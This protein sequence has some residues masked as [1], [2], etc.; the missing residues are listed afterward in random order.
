MAAYSRHHRHRLC[1]SAVGTST[2]QPAPPPARRGP[3]RHLLFPLA[4]GPI[5]PQARRYKQRRR[6]ASAKTPSLSTPLV[7]VEANPEIFLFFF[8]QKQVHVSSLSSRWKRSGS[9]SRARGEA[10]RGPFSTPEAEGP[11]RLG[12]ICSP[13]SHSKGK[14]QYAPQQSFAED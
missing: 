6:R 12:A 3:K 11:S 5:S 8:Q 14:D 2:S 4:C 13:P 10:R 1:A 7:P 9:G